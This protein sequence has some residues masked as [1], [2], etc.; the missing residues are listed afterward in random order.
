MANQ[1]KRKMTGTKT[2][3]APSKR[4][5][6]EPDA[7]KGEGAKP[8]ALPAGAIEKVYKGKTIAVTRDAEGFHFDGKLFKSLTAVALAVTGYQTISGPAFF[9][10]AKRATKGGA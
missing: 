9:G 4:P 2:R 10:L 6:K 8:A 5:A 3:K 1:H 7:P